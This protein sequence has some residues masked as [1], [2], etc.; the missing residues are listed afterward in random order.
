MIDVIGVALAAG[1]GLSWPR[2]ALVAAAL[3][4]PIPTLGVIAVA[5]ARLRAG[6]PNAVGFCD[7]ISAE[8][9]AGS[10]LRLA[11]AAAARSVGADDIARAAGAGAPMD[12]I[13]RLVVSVFPEVGEE[14]GLAVRE[15][16]VS[17]S[18]GADLFDEMGTLALANQEV[19]REVRVASA[20]ARAT[21]A[22]FVAGPSLYLLVQARSGS[23]SALVA[24]PGQRVAA[25]VGLGLFATGLM[26]AMVILWRAR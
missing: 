1:M 15:L 6:K 23:L 7:G 21:A 20:P 13:S 10:S 25:V 18:G 5:Q 17:G 9:R 16:A 19:A 14:L 12:E 2:V 24:A 4:W 3:Y 8:L 22:L 11:I 26:I